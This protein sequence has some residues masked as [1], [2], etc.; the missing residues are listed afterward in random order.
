MTSIRKSLISTITKDDLF[1]RVALAIATVAVLFISW[2]VV[3]TVAAFTTPSS[4]WSKIAEKCYPDP[5][6]LDDAAVFL[7]IVLIPAAYS[8]FYLEHVGFVVMLPNI[9]QPGSGSFAAS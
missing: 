4:R 1:V 9:C 2:G 6:G 8:L 3:V 5:A 7:V